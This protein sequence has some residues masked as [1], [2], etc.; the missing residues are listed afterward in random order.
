MRIIKVQE[1]KTYAIDRMHSSI[2]LSWLKTAIVICC[3][4]IKWAQADNCLRPLDIMV[5]VS[6]HLDRKRSDAAE[7][8]KSD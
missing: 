4:V 8:F 5:F 3:S 1:Y 2:L 7:L 6:T